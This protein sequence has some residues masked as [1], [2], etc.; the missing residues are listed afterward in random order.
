[1]MRARTAPFSKGDAAF[2]EEELLNDERERVAS[3]LDRTAR[4]LRSDSD[5]RGAVIRCYKLISQALEAKSSIDGRTLTAS[6]FREVISE[7]LKFD[8]PYLSKATLLFEVARYSEHPITL[9]DALEASE[10]LSNL[11]EALREQVAPVS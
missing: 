9:E 8:S 1:M 4:E 7:R 10:C 5:Y 6:E 2:E 3:I 11:S